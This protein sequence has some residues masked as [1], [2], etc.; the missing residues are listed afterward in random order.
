M[1]WK[2]TGFVKELKEGLSVTEKFVLLV[3]ADYHRT[4]DKGAWPSLRTLA[5][6]CL[7]TERGVQQIIA[8]LVE[9]EFLEKISGCGRGNVSGYRIIGIDG[10]GEPQTSN[11]HSSF[12]HS[13][14]GGAEKDERKRVKDAQP[15]SAIRNE[16]IE[17][18]NRTGEQPGEFIPPD[19]HGIQA[20]AKLVQQVQESGYEL[21]QS[22]ALSRAITAAFDALVAGGKSPPGAFEY[23][24]AV[25][26]DGIERGERIDKF[27]FEDAKW[28]GNAGLAEKPPGGTN[29]S[30]RSQRSIDSLRRSL[31]RHRA[32]ERDAHNAGKREDGTG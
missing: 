26:L 11:A 7:M 28:R 9:G 18:I 17:P 20:A 25:T 10:K 24:L 12:A 15:C 8:R 31:A 6:D 4:D 23:L 19:L 2:A 16:P 32:G 5:S 22:F 29:S 21:P 27:W 13:S 14:N 30:T 1:S 3:L